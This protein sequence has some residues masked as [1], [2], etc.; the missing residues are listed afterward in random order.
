MGPV[1]FTQLAEGRLSWC[2][3][4]RYV[5]RELL[6]LHPPEAL[7]RADSLCVCLRGRHGGSASDRHARSAAV[8]R[9]IGMSTRG[10]LAV[11]SCQP[12]PSGTPTIAFIPSKL[13]LKKK[14][15]KKKAACY[16]CYLH[17]SPHLIINEE[18]MKAEWEFLVHVCYWGHVNLGWLFKIMYFNVYSYQ[19]LQ[20]M[21]LH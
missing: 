18:Q 13:L 20:S 4:A 21:I 15:K 5:F 9:A 3:R 7:A 16:L 17:T 8:R 11:F 6:K 2:Q 12:P 10:Q 19:T 14:K 1:L